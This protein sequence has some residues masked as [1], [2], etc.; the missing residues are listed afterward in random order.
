MILA[1]IPAQF[2]IDWTLIGMR[3]GWIDV[4]FLFAFGFGVYVGLKNGLAKILPRFFQVVV[5]QVVV[6]EYSKPLAAFLQI[7]F[8]IPLEILHIVLFAVLAIGSIVLIHFLFQLLTLIATVDFKAPIN[9]VGGALL[10][11]FQ[12]ILFLGLVSS[13]LLL[14]PL[15]FIQDTFHNR[16]LSGPYLAESSGQVHDFFAKWLPNTWRAS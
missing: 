14:F 5:A 11:G 16:S 4:V 15:P 10:S 8:L 6:V 3:M 9:N 12:W 1:A 7:R 2:H 13:F